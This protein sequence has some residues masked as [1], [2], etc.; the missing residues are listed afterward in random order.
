MKPSVRTPLPGPRARALLERGEK[1]LSPSYVRPYPFVPARGQGAFLEDVDGNLFLDFMSG[2]AVNTTGYAHPKVVEAVKRQLDRMPMS[3]RVLVSEPTAR[4]AAKLA[5]ITPEGL[6]MV[7]FGNSGAEAVEAAI[8]LARAY[9]GKPGIV[10]T[11][12]G[13]HGKTMGALSLTP[14]PEYQD[15][16]RPLLPGVK[17]AGVP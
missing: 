9:T 4:L 3:V 15:P 7:F 16:A 1:V 5:E 17:A 10:T 14:K 12:G 2:I 8:K 11:Q 13:F 6:E